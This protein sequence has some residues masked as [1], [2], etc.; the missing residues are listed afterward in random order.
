MKLFILMLFLILFSPV[1]IINA[2][3]SWD[4]HDPSLGPLTNSYWMRPWHEV[5]LRSPADTRWI[6]EE[7]MQDNL[8]EAPFQPSFSPQ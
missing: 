1:M 6:P 7:D 8:P 3:E 4:Y 5:I 2:A